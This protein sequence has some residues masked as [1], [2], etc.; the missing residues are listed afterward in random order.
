MFHLPVSHLNEKI[1]QKLIN[2]N[3]NF[4]ARCLF[5]LHPFL[6]A[7]ERKWAFEVGGKVDRGPGGTKPHFILNQALK[8]APIPGSRRATV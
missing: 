3:I 7:A 5:A 1:P 8:S 6:S 4:R 2:A